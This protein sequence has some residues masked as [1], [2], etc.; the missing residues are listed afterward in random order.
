MTQEKAQNIREMFGRIAP[1]YDLLN[2]TLS[3]SI[4]QRWRKKAISYLPSRENLKVLDLCAGTLDLTLAILKKFPHAEITALDFSDKM[5]EIGQRKI[6][7]DK[8]SQVKIVVGDAMHLE[9]PSE[10][11]DAVICGFGMRNVVDNAKC[12]AEIHR[13][14]NPLGRII[15]LEFFHPTTFQGRLFHQTFGKHLL[16]R[17]G[18]WLSKDKQAYSYLFNS[19]Q[20]YHSVQDFVKILIH[21]NFHL[22]AQKNLT[23]HIASIV[24]GQK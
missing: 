24:V 10:S 19:I 9:L 3:G 20:S 18:A 17:I 16:P 23:G 21:K 4:D 15:V 22:L 1:T 14:L 5:L 6:P 7:A 8:K 12:L 11:F 13:V 2:R